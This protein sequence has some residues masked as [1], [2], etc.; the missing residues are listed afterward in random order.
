MYLIV[1]RTQNKTK[2]ILSYI[3]LF[4]QIDIY[5][6]KFLWQLIISNYYFFNI[7]HYWTHF[8]I[9]IYVI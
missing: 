9:Y 6:L 3:T 8:L 2:S 5:F 1:Y 4:Y 7:Y